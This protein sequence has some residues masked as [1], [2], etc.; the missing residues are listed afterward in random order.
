M[1]RIPWSPLC[2]S[3]PSKLF[4]EIEKVLTLLIVRM[5]L[6]GSVPLKLFEEASNTLS[7][8]RITW[9]PL[10]GSAPSKLFEEVSKNVR[11]DITWSPLSGSAPSKLFEDVSKNLRARITWSPLSGSAPSN[12]F[13]PWMSKKYTAL[14]FPIAF[15]GSTPSNPFDRIENCL[16]ALIVRMPLSGS[17]PLKVLKSR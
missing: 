11:H 4:K 17:V 2:G 10:S 5:P 7:R 3:A 14:I 12:C 15:T 8:L 6:P 16:T 13:C 9:S 1:A